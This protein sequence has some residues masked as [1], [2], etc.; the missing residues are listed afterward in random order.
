MGQNLSRASGSLTHDDLG[1]VAHKVTVLFGTG[2]KPVIASLASQNKG[3]SQPSKIEP[4][5]RDLHYRCEFSW[6]W[7]RQVLWVTM[8]Q[9]P[10]QVPSFKSLLIRYVIS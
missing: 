4:L 6:V 7:V 8:G 9:L 10:M 2:P 1:C 3:E 5:S